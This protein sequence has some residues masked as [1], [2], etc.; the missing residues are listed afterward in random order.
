MKSIELTKE[1]KTKLLEMCNKLF[2]EKGKWFEILCGKI[3]Y[4]RNGKFPGKSIHWFEFCMTH[5]FLKI[6]P[7]TNSMSFGKPCK[8][9]NSIQH[10]NYLVHWLAGYPNDYFGKIINLEKYHPIDYIYEEFKKIN[11]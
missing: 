2:P 7:D 4:S 9:S 11:K 5:L 1:H 10:Y 6:F 3:Y 8:I